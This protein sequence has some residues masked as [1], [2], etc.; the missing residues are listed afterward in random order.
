MREEVLIPNPKEV[1]RRRQRL[2]YVSAISSWEWLR[3][4]KVVDQVNQLYSKLKLLSCQVGNLSYQDVFYDPRVGINIIFKSLVLEA[5]PDKTL[6]FSK[7]RLQW[8]S[9]QTI[10]MEGILRVVQTKIG[11]YGI[12]LDYHIFDIPKGDPP[13]I[14]I[15]RPIE[16]VLSS[17]LDHEKYPYHLEVRDAHLQFHRPGVKKEHVWSMDILEASTLYSKNRLEHEGFTLE[18]SQ[19]PCSHQKFPELSSSITSDLYETYN[20]FIFLVHAN[21]ERKVVDAFVYHKH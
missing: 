16:G 14:L 12:F 19:I 13:F 18:G 4:T 6:T 15:G 1:E 2:E 8:I 9:S 10:E 11:E 3:E 21:L 7:K 5:F 20:L 17:V